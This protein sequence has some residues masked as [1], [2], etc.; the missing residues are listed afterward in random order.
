M[1][2]LVPSGRWA[3][4]FG[5]VAS[6]FASALGRPSSAHA[7]PPPDPAARLQFVIHKI[8]IL[9]DEDLFGGGEEKFFVLLCGDSGTSPYNR[10][11][12]CGPGASSAFEYA[13]DASSGDD[14]SLERVSPRE[15]DYMEGGATPESG[16]PVYAGQHYIFSAD[17][18]DRD[19]AY[20]YDT[21]GD[22]FVH[23]DEEHNWGLGTHTARS[24][25][26]NGDPGDYEL[27][28]EIR[29]APLPD[30]VVKSVYIQDSPGMPFVCAD[31]RN[32][33]ER[34]A[35]P[36]ELTV[37]TEGTVLE[38]FRLPALDVGWSYPHCIR[39]SDLPAKK[40]NLVF[41]LDEMRELPE[42]DEFNNAGVL[43]SK[44]SRL[45][46]TLALRQH[47]SLPTRTPAPR[48]H[49]SLPTATRARR[50]R[51]SQTAPILAAAPRRSQ[52]RAMTW[53]TCRCARS[54]STARHRMARTPARTARTT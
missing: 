34:P 27:S 10:S 14:V 46:P 23:V 5:I 35:G 6:V 3:L 52:S 13:L 21:M 1:A 40:H 31:I 17:M 4:A 37:Q 32:V 51:R 15:G 22:I 42:M 36:A 18:F 45:P 48:P 44:P 11:F 38:R 54:V 50:R 41:S 29:R 12:A 7:D 33:G 19:P 20:A 49:P 28:F 39:R 9:D 53:P 26:E 8:H 24:I 30:L 43:T 25:Q 16:I 47:R 2:G